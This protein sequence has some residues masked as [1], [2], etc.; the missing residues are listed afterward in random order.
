MKHTRRHFSEPFAFFENFIPKKPV[1]C[2]SP[3]LLPTLI[4][5]PLC[6]SSCVWGKVSGFIIMCLLWLFYSDFKIQR[7]NIFMNS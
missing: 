1:H 5:I 6:L 4:S 3:S 7:L 2:L